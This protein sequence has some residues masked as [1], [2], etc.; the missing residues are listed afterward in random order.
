MLQRKYEQLDRYKRILGTCYTVENIKFKKKLT[1]VLGKNINSEMVSNGQAV[2]YRK[3]S[4]DYIDDEEVAKNKKMMRMANLG[5]QRSYMN[6]IKNQINPK[7]KKNLSDEVELPGLK[8]A[9]SQ[10]A[11]PML[12]NDELIG[13][14][15]VE[16]KK[17]NINV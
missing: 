11:I 16:S 9:E 1:S 13:V 6:A 10:V 7:E 17:I 12:F 15:S 3:Y 8:N 2:A 14:L 4:K 5:M